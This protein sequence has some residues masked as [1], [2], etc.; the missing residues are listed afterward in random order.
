M[1]ICCCFLTDAAAADHDDD[2][3]FYVPFNIFKPYR[4]DGKETKAVQW[5]A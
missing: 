5:S 3:V 1:D 4:D 2:F